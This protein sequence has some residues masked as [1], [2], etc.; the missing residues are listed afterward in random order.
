MDNEDEMIEHIGAFMALCSTITTNGASKPD[1]YKAEYQSL[2]RIL[3]ETE[4]LRLPIWIRSSSTPANVL[5]HVKMEK[6]S[7]SGTWALRRDYFHQEKMKL[8]ESLPATGT[9][10]AA[11]KADSPLIQRKTAAEVGTFSQ[12]TVSSASSVAFRTDKKKVFIVHGHDGE[13]KYQVARL[14]DELGFESIIFHEQPNHGRSIFQKL[15]EL[16]AAVDYAVVL[17]TACDIGK[18]AGTSL[19][20]PRARQ[21]VVFEHGYLLARLGAGKVTAIRE[22]EVEKPSD[23]DGVLYIS[24][25]DN[26]MYQL[27]R[28]LKSLG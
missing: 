10:I 7:G 22:A 24:V 21:N 26:W 2:R 28:E 5:A 8:L 20:K 13:L 9:T 23:L 25:D 3:M 19:E 6:G 18:V 27:S 14:V 1:S 4:G 11:P 17:Y 15:T 12:R 16:T